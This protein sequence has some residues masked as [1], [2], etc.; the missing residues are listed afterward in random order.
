MELI[1][2]ENI[3]NEYLLLDACKNGNSSTLILHKEYFTNNLNKE[4]FIKA[5]SD[6]IIYEHLY[7]IKCLNKIQSIF[8]QDDNVIKDLLILACNTNNIEIIEYMINNIK[9][10][11]I[12]E[13]V[14]FHI[15]Q[16]ND[17]DIIKYFHSHLQ[18]YK[19][20]D[21]NQSRRIDYS[22][23]FYIS[24]KCNRLNIGQYL[25]SNCIID[26]NYRRGGPLVYACKNNNIDIIKWLY[27]IRVND[28]CR[29]YGGIR[30]LCRYGYL[31][32]LKWILNQKSNNDIIGIFKI[33]KYSCFRI[34]CLYGHINIAELILSYFKGLQYKDMIFSFGINFYSLLLQ[35]KQDH[36][37]N[38]LKTL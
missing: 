25:Y 32:N 15:C 8:D 7:I 26:I 29:N 6:A 24:I 14:F 9:N 18:T 34:A 16:Y 1:N 2:V 35:H 12:I 36:I 33:N 31:D 20:I 4:L 38:W 23:A 10:K 21:H 28:H 13:K 27:Q 22:Q 17:L 3:I 30:T 11:L 5:I 37:V 19:Y